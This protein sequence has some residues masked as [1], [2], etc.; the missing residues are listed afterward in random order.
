MRITLSTV[1]SRLSI[2]FSFHIVHMYFNK[3]AFI[4]LN[5][6]NSLSFKEW[7]LPADKEERRRIALGEYLNS[8]KRGEDAKSKANLNEFENDRLIQCTSARSS[9]RTTGWRSGADSLLKKSIRN[10]WVKVSSFL[11]ATRAFINNENR[12]T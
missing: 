4:S 8:M 1:S 2:C 3:Q 5:R 7:K 10:A 12:F 9:T 6:N 11:L